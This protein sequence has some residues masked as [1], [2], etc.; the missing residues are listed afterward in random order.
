MAP[1]ILNFL[2][3]EQAGLLKDV[4]NICVILDGWS[5]ISKI[6]YAAVILKFDTTDSKSQYEYIG[7]KL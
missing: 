4:Q 1:Q 7:L 3:E 6:N 5:D 2:K